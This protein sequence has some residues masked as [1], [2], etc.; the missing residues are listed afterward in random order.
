MKKKNLELNAEKTKLMRFRKGAER[1]GKR[2]WRW[3]GKRI[4][5]VKKYKYLGCVMQKNGKQEAHF[6]ERT[7]RAAIVMRQVWE[8]GKRRFE[9]DWEGRIYSID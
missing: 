6:R 7:K 3:K 9:M 1:E 5:E 4:E 2:E 8:I